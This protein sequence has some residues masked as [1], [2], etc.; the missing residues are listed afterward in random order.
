MWLFNFFKWLI[1]RWVRKLLGC[2]RGSWWSELPWVFLLL[3]GDGGI[4]GW[5]QGSAQPC[6]KNL[7]KCFQ[8]GGKV[9]G[10]DSYSYQKGPSSF[11]S[12]VYF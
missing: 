1:N 11:G 5:G 3:H 2:C 7:S 6:G 9:L 4:R 12:S 10:G 8:E